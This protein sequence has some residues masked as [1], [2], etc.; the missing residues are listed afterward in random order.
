MHKLRFWLKELLFILLNIQQVK[1]RFLGWLKK[2]F[3]NLT[4]NS[5]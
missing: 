4:S 5:L 1:W 2:D 3:A